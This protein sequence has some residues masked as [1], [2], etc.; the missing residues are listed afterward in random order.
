[1]FDLKQLNDAISSSAAAFRCVT[2]Y[3]PMAGKGTAVFPSTYEGGKYATVGYRVVDQTIDV[4]G[5]PVKDS[6]RKLADQVVLDSVQSQANRMELALLEAWLDKRI[7]LPVVTVDFAGNELEKDLRITSLEAPHRIADAILRDSLLAGVP[8]RKSDV[9]K[10]LDHVDLRNATALFELCPTA[11]VFGVWDSTGP[12]GGLGAKFQR[13]V[14]SELV[15]LDAQIGV[16]TSSRIDPLQCRA[17]VRVTPQKDGSWKVAKDGK[18][19]GAVS[20]AEVNHGNIPPSFADGGVTVE[21]ALQT[22]VLSLVALRRLRFPLVAGERSK[23]EVDAAAR[24]TLAALALC[25]AALTREAGC[26]LRSRCQLF[27]TEAIRWELLD[28]PGQEPQVIDLD[29]KSAIDLFNESVDAAKKVGLPWLDEE[30]VL[31]PS[32]QLVELVQK[33]QQLATA[34]AG[35]DE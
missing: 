27:P 24:T 5:K 35:G 15:G 9:G 8:F 2:E 17:A 28:K 26:D 22:T 29:A 4:D 1:M 23:P 11:L 20:P 13:A 14:V 10:A 16:K 34:G 12:K 33:S 25:A 6:G 30:L 19:K 7:R 21:K 31:T 18:A 3:Q 32:P